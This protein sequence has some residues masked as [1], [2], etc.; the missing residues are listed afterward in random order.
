MTTSKGDSK[1]RDTRDQERFVI[2]DGQSYIYR[3]FFA[4]RRLS[5]SK[6]LPTNAIYGF[7][8]MMQ[9]ILKELK[10]DYIC[11]VFDSKGPTFRHEIYRD[12]KANRPPMPDDLSIQIP[13][14]HDLVDLYNIKKIAIAG[15]EADDIIAT[16]ARRGERE[17]KEVI[18]ISGDKDL[19]QFVNNNISIYDTMKDKVYRP[20]DVEERYGVMPE[21][22]VD[23][24]ALAGDS[25][26]N[27]PG[28]RGI[29]EKTALSLIKRYGHIE[30]ILK[31]IDAIEPK[32]LAEKIRSSQSDILLSYRLVSLREDL[33]INID[34]TDLK[35]Q[36][37]DKERL[38]KLF[39]EYE[40]RTL[41]EVSDKDQMEEKI[42]E[43]KKK[44]YRTILT[45]EDLE[46][47]LKKLER[48]EEV[49]ID[50]ETDSIRACDA[51]LVGISICIEEDI[52]YYIPLMHR[53]LGCPR[54]LDATLVRER[55]NPILSQKRLIGQNIK[56]D[57]LVLRS[58]G[59]DSLE[60]Y[61]DTMIAAYLLDPEA[62]SHSLRAI[63]RRYLDYQMFTYQEVT[64]S[65]GKREASFADVDIKTATLYSGEDA[66]ITFKL[67]KVLRKRLKDD[68][69]YDLY[70]DVEMPLVTILAD[71]EYTGVYVNAG[72]LTELSDF[73]NRKIEEEERVIYEMAGERFNINSTKSLANILFEKL[74][75]PQIKQTRTGSSTDSQVLEGLIDK[76]EIIRHIIEYRG[77]NKIKNTY[78]DALKTLISRRSG[79]IHTNFNQTATA[80]GRLSSSEPNL[81]NIPIKTET[82]RLV[83][84]AFEA[85]EGYSLMSAD[86][87]QIELRIFAHMSKD[88]TLGKAF[89][90]G[91]DIHTRTA[92]EIFEKS[93]EEISHE[94]RRL[95]KTINFGIIYGMGAFRLAATLGINRKEAQEYID[96][97]FRRISGVKA[98]INRMIEDARREQCV[99]TLLGRKRY[100]RNI[101]SNSPSVRQAEER[102][103]VN[104][105]IQGSAADIIKLAMIN[106]YKKIKGSKVKM[107]LQVHDELV[108]EIPNDCI[109][110]ISNLVKTEME[111]VVRLSVPL[112]AEIS[113]GK[114][115]AEAK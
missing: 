70:R 85:R 59:Y 48:T 43:L 46:S 77:L 95:A 97:Y 80:T 18:I 5:T 10:P 56:Y 101:N 2:I 66:D 30:E 110:E 20:K 40:F 103:A 93:P 111:K 38:N 108:F 29:G 39:A 44:D 62:D 78:A 11:I 52:S 12:Y 57:L 16:L 8:T 55:L 73:L 89:L 17:G 90:D 28:A 26:D 79:R 9:K 91:E 51:N 13:H 64:G 37:P 24:L 82:G 33:D 86:Y 1:N 115:W 47:L 36:E 105:P 67:S 35:A 106:I 21:Y 23:L 81:Q 113:I 99:K 96:R 102:M 112:V 88:P 6:G 58:N 75:L 63:A 72:K 114:N 45:V 41:V 15:Y 34:F 7:V 3:A 107:I 60:A 87:S 68:R 54:Q 50:T 104:T 32:S 74:N 31:N 27:I 25:T 4:I 83:R 92:C 100:L 49:C 71:M 76:H 61:D 42:S 98:F 69:L 14:I 94:M 84:A 19:M 53:Y 65:K 109:G 22:I